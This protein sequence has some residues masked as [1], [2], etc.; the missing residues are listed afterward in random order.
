[1]SDINNP[2][3][4]GKVA[5]L[6]GGTS[7]ERGISLLSGAA[8]L[9]SLLDSG[10]DACGIDVGQNIFVELQEKAIDRVFIMLHGRNGED[11]KMQAA[12]ELIGMPYTGSG[13]LASALAMD[14]VRCKQLWRALGLNTPNFVVLTE[15]TDW[16]AVINKLGTSFVKPVKEGSSIGI[17]KA[18]SVEELKQAYENARQYDNDVIAEQWIDGPEYTVAILGDLTLP[19]IEL[20]TKHEFYDYDAKYEA[21]DT[22]YICPCDLNATKKDEIQSLSKTAFDVLG[23]YGWGRVDLMQDKA[24]EF[25][26]LDLNTIPGMTDHSLV[27]MAAKH[28]GFD[29]DA[30]VLSILSSSNLDRERV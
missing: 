2:K 17:G 30:L 14:K 12:M 7:A 10:V 13:V 27:P 28:T 24:G 20:K 16:Q 9:K 18:S 21:Q 25:W 23:C 8:V 19:V 6:M 3:S 1:M 11:G 4:F 15:N 5:V 29:F 26:L 22:E